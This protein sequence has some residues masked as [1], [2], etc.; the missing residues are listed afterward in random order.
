[1]STQENQWFYISPPTAASG[2][3]SFPP[4]QVL[5]TTTSA[6]AANYDW[7]TALG[8]A[9]VRPR[10]AVMITL[11]ASSNDVWVRFKSG[12]PTAAAAVAAT[13]ITNGLIVK[14]NQPGRTW[15]PID[16]EKFGVIDHIAAG[17]GTLQVQVS[18]F[19]GARTVQ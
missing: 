18:S 11:E 15:G 14:A 7:A 1:M 5:S 4:N 6:A 19:P 13:T 9:S 12:P 8:S 10:G 16:P 3:G 17:A 2:V